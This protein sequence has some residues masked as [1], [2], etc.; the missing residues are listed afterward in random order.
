MRTPIPEAL[1]ERIEAIH[2]E[3]GYA[4]KSEFV[5]D[6]VRHW[7]ANVEEKPYKPRSIEEIH[8]EYSIHSPEAVDNHKVKLTPK[9]KSDLH[10]TYH[11][12]GHPNNSVSLTLNDDQKISR[13]AIESALSEIK[14][15]SRAVFN[16]DPAIAVKISKDTDRLVSDIVC[17]I[18]NNLY[19]TI[20]IETGGAFSGRQEEQLQNALDQY[21]DKV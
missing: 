15:V 13:E 10:M 17:D 14:G 2:E 7:L 20:D 21:A 16:T 11:T 12:P 19:K 4:T 6:A 3:A 5:R 18:F 9:K 1:E 8:F